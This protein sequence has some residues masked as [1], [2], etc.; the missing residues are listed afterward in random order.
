MLLERLPDGSLTEWALDPCCDR[1]KSVPNTFEEFPWCRTNG[2]DDR[3]EFA[4]TAGKWLLFPSCDATLAQ[5]TAVAAEVARGGLW[6]A[7]VSLTN[8]APAK[9][10]HVVCIYTRD[11]GDAAE[12]LRAGQRLQALRLAPARGAIFYKPDLFTEE[13]RYSGTAPASI[14]GLRAGSGFLFK[15][16]GFKALP[17]EL[18]TR[19]D[20]A[21]AALQ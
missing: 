18:Q 6:H 19:L 14:F 11:A 4:S 15:T 20:E 5:W 7:K 2:A 10:S 8:S 3:P 21:L 13:E 1:L 9:P 12:T 16:A 17:V